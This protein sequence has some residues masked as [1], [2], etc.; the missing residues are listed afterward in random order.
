ME[1]EL[2]V[3]GLIV[4]FIFKAVYKKSIVKINFDYIKEQHST[5][6]I[7]LKL[8]FTIVEV[9]FIILFI[10]FLMDLNFYF[11]GSV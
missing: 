6:Y 3:L 1:L 11:F 9:A 7:L 8:I 2:I 4:S 10:C 5:S